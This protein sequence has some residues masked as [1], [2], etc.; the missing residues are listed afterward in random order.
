MDEIEKIVKQL[1]QIERANGIWGV[2][3]I[4]AIG[5]FL[6]LLFTFMKSF[7]EKW[8]QQTINRELE[9]YKKQL[10][11]ELGTTIVEKLSE[12][13]KE[14]ATLKATLNTSTQKKLSYHSEQVESYRKVYGI[15]ISW[16]HKLTD[17]HHGGVNMWDG[18]DIRKRVAMLSQM[19]NNIKIEIAKLRMYSEDGELIDKINHVHKTILDNVYIPPKQYLLK[20]R[21]WL[22]E[23]NSCQ[24][25][26]EMKTKISEKDELSNEF[27][28]NLL[29]SLK[30]VTPD[31]QEFHK[32]Y[33]EKYKTLITN[34]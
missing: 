1:D 14:I 25:P 17:P 6:W 24:T 2:V 34:E 20:V 26:E 19:S 8:G 5:L 32:Y 16:F 11:Q 15:I 13:N 28:Q 27:N 3:T 29:E 33:R 18:E 4:L 9:A 7:V 12:V 22:P 10:N 23:Y 31:I 21:K 30:T